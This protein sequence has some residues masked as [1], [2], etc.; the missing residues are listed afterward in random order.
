MTSVDKAQRKHFIDLGGNTRLD[1]QAT[2]TR[3]E[4]KEKVVEKEVT[5]APITSGLGR[6]LD[7]TV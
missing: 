6:V 1:R 3:K 5:K 2:E 7:R 4:D